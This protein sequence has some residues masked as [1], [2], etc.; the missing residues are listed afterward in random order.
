M[1]KGEFL[2]LPGGSLASS[3]DTWRGD[4]M[5]GSQPTDKRHPQLARS[6]AWQK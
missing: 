3:V 4:K 2:R 5:Q 1:V 6:P